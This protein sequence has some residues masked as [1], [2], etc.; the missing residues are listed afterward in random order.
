MLSFE[1]RRVLVGNLC[2]LGKSLDISYYVI[3]KVWNCFFKIR[4]WEVLESNLFVFMI[5]YSW[6]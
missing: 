6:G 1:V 2:D 5:F 4:E 3:F